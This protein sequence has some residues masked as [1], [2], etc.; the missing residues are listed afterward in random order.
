MFG[1]KTTQ[2]DA[3]VASLAGLKQKAR[4]NVMI[5]AAAVCVAAGAVASSAFALDPG[6]RPI[7]INNAVVIDTTK[8]QVIIEL[9]PQM[10]PKNVAQFETLTKRHFYD[11]L[12][13]HRVMENFMDQ[14]GDPKGTGEGGSDLP[15]V[16]GEFTVR[17]DVNFPLNVAARPSGSLIGFVGAMPVQSQVH[18]LAA[19]TTDGK[20]DSWGLFCQGTVGMARDNDPD[21][22]NS[23]FFLMRDVYPTLEKNYTAIG[24]VVSGVDVVR[25]IKLGVPAV[26]PDKMVKVRMLSEIPE[27]ERPKVEIMDTSSPQFKAVLDQ[28]RKTKGADFSVCDVTVPVKVNGKLTAASVAA[29]PAPKK[30]APS[31]FLTGFSPGAVNEVPMNSSSNTKEG[32][33]GGY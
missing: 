4:K 10:A 33:G 19:I 3:A 9:Y 7:D 1:A 31:P 26:N 17:Q 16:P 14:T 32:G 20:I 18:E 22:A 29:A 11:G 21:S 6:Y 15:N 28:N 12:I 13:F 2:R 23:Q 25:K 5:C 30:Q 27:A 8:G 24:T